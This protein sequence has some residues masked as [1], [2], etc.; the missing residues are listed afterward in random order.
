MIRPRVWWLLL[1]AFPAFGQVSETVTVNVVEV[2]VTVVDRAGQPVKGLTKN[3]FE[4]YVDGKKVTVTGFDTVD[5]ATVDQQPLTRPVPTAAYRNFLLLF[6]LSASSPGTIGRAQA[7]ASEFIEKHMKRRDR[8]AVAMFSVEKGPRILTGF[9]SD[10]ELLRHVI[11]N[12]VAP[13]L[14]KV[15][16]KKK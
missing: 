5:I 16:G 7:A 14:I 11:E 10:R 8:T 3:D 13:E 12:V 2:P 9:T 1:L 15:P 4:L 6:D